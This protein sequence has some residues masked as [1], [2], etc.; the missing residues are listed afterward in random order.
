VNEALAIRKRTDVAKLKELQTKMPGALEILSVVGDPPR[1]VKL[2][3]R[4]PTAMNNRYP[5]QKQD[6][7][8]VEIQLPEGY[9]LPPAGVPF[10]N[11]MTPIWN[12]NVY[13]SGKW[14]FGEW[15]ITEN[16]E[17]FVVR[18]MKVI[19]LDPTII[20]PRSA[21]NGDAAHWYVQL[22]EQRSGL[23]PT[24]SIAELMSEKPKIAW[25]TIK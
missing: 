18:L 11:F 13:P 4:I 15:T 8:E 24:V 14:C 9:P 10:V 5:Q 20:N 17:L 21:A 12:P 3:I 2:R 7:S 1:S 22:L 25:R 16:L 6:I 23:F 19:A